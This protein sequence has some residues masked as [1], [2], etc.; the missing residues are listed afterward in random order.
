MSVFHVINFICVFMSSSSHF[1]LLAS[2]SSCY[3]PKDQNF[4]QKSDRFW[5][6]NE[7]TNSWVEIQLPYDLISC[8]N[9]NCTVV[10][11]IDSR[12]RRNENL[13]KED[14]DDV[15]DKKGS[16][17]D[18]G[19]E[20]FDVV[21]P[22]RKRF[23]LTKMSETSIW[24]TGVSGS[25]YERFWNEIQWVIAPHDLPVSAGPAVSVFSINHTILATSEAGILYQVPT[26]FPGFNEKTRLKY[27]KATIVYCGFQS[28]KS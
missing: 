19:D 18:E 3:L 12:K 11:S 13:R 16:F 8:V 7:E 6:F 27:I 17:R 2:S 20:N 9:D 4:E 10:G 28:K 15:P 23:S 24:V 1:L 26:D 14:D 25:I 5:E 21:L 22:Q